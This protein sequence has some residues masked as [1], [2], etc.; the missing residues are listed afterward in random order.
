MIIYA[1]MMPHPPVAIPEIGRGEERKIQ[2]TLDSY[3]KVTKKIAELKPETIVLSTPHTTMYR[4]YFLISPGKHAHGDFSRYRH[5]EVSF[6]I[7]YDEEFT[8]M[9]ADECHEHGMAAG[10]DYERD[11]N[12]DQGAMVPLYYINQE[13]RNYRLVRVGLSGQPL[14]EHYKLGER[15]QH[16]TEKLGRRVVYVASG[17]L[18]HCQ[19]ASGPYGFHP[20]GPE[21]D[22][23]IMK[24]MGSANFGE[25]FDYDPVFLEKAEECGHRSFVI[26]AGALDGYSVTPHVLTHEA[27]LGV[28]YGFVGYEVGEKDERRHFLRDYEEKIRSTAGKSTD[29]YVKLARDSVTSWVSRRKKL[30]VP[31]GLPEAMLST[32]AGAFVSI[33]EFGELRGCIGTIAPTQKCIAEE[34]IRNGISACS[35][36]PRFDPIRED[37]LPYLTISV[38]VLGKAEDIKSPDELDVKRYGVICSTPDGRR[39]LLLPDLDGVDTVE[40]QIQIACK[41]GGIGRR[42]P[43]LRLQRF[44]VVRH[45]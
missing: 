5:P 30:P 35:R 20:E 38:D 15:I 1:F 8:K 3:K 11:P 27:T 24:T 23:R 31:D 34:I 44:E 33:H 40:Q 41:K 26:M 39:G 18:S 22:A 6:E 28:G 37:E 25:L 17:D 45:V 36:D 10:T 14:P 16:V 43:G 13:Y 42:E 9:L 12:L 32:R 2:P 29:P 21:Y 7:D 19:L 4:D